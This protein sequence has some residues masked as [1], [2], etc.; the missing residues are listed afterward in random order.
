[1]S[2]FCETRLSH[3]CPFL[4]LFAHTFVLHFAKSVTIQLKSCL[5]TEPIQD[6]REEFIVTDLFTRTG[7]CVSFILYLEDIK[8]FGS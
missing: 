6:K 3:D 2:T 7:D 5:L 8:V 1:M 4:T